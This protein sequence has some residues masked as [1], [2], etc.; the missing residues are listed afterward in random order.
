M[1]GGVGTSYGSIKSFNVVYTVISNM[2]NT[3]IKWTIHTTQGNDLFMYSSWRYKVSSPLNGES[4]SFHRFWNLSDAA[5]SSSPSESRSS[6][7]FFFK[8]SIDLLQRE[9]TPSTTLSM[10]D[11]W[12]FVFSFSCNRKNAPSFCLS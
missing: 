11:C 5:R 1:T 10:T 7:T 4:S 12:S 6:V 2:N 8:C 3:I 9:V